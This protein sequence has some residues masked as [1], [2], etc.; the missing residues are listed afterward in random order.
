LPGFSFCFREGAR[1][2]PARR[3]PTAPKEAKKQAGKKGYVQASNDNISNLFL[4][5]DLVPE[6][7]KGTDKFLDVVNWN[8]R[9]FHDKDQDRVKTVVEILTE[10]NADVIVLVEILEGSLDIVAKAL[11]GRKAGYY[12]VAYGTT[13]GN[14]RVAMMWD[15]DWV[16]TKDDIGEIFAR[17]EVTTGIGKDVFPRLPLHGYFTSLNKDTDQDPFDF[18]LLG[19]HLK[20]QRGGG[21][22]QRKMAAERLAKWLADEAPKQ[23]A[24]VLIVGDWNERPDSRTWQPFHQ[25]EKQGKAA[26]EKINDS[27]NI[28]HLMYRNATDVGSRLDLQVISAAALPGVAAPPQVVTWKPLS[29]MLNRKGGT[30]AQKLK[31]LIKEISNDISDH[32]PVVSRFYFTGKE[33]KGRK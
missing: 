30:K 29:D 22:D 8:I 31:A 1:K 28:S 25:L 18:Q 5:H 7:M 16:R 6:K 15:L 10:L 20:S 9:Y 2:N 13:G 26:F 11:A 21:E 27:S 19:V 17:G 14:Q 3:N 4:L 12:N 33:E 32:M 24:D 23:D